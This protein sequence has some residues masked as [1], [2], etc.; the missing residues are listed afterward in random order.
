VK[1]YY[2]Q[3]GIEIFLGDCRDVLPT[4]SGINCTMT[5]PPYNTLG[6]RVPKEGTNLMKGN[7]WLA[8]VN[9]HGYEDT[10]DEYEYQSEQA[11]IANMI[12]A[13]TIPGGS[14]FYNHKVRY[15]DSEVLHPL[16]IVSDFYGWTIRQEIIWDRTIAMAF[17]ARMFAPSDERIYWLWRNDAPHKW[18]QE[19]SKWMSIWRVSPL[20][21]DGLDHPCPFPNVIA[22]RCILATT[23]PGDLI[24]DPFMGSGTTLRAAKDLG[25]RAVGIE[26]E[27][28]FA[29]MAVDRLA[30]GVLF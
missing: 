1:P 25:R 14:F 21:S 27:E 23:D 3:D 9:E 26:T 15:R 5:S 12:R 17:N 11:E 8:K 2:S 19:A 6:N 20:T 28:R 18:N 13:A 30:Q 24:C 29:E 4:L 7:G 16:T 10:M 22:E